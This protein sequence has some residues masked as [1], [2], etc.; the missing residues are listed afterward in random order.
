MCIDSYILATLPTMLIHINIGNTI[1]N[2]IL[3]Q[4]KMLYERIPA[5][6]D[7]LPGSLEW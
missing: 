5:I 6:I 4:T 1:Q 3:S 7:I 2:H